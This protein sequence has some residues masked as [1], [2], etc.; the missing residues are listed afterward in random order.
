[1]TGHLAM[2][3]ADRRKKIRLLQELRASLRRDGDRAVHDLCK[4][5]VGFKLWDEAHAIRWALGY[6]E[7]HVNLE[8]GKLTISLEPEEVA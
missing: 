3:P 8:T 6:V 1:M 2:T 7:Q 4:K 5:S